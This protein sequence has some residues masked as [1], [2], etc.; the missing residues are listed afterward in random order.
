MSQPTSEC[1][2]SFVGRSNTIDFTNWLA[3]L[4]SEMGAA[5]YSQH[6]L[7][8]GE[9][10]VCIAAKLPVDFTLTDWEQGRVFNEEFELRWHLHDD[11]VALLLLT[12]QENKNVACAD[13]CDWQES[14]VCYTATPMQQMLVGTF[15]RRDGDGFFAEAAVPRAFRYPFGKN[16][17][18]QMRSHAILHGK[19]YR[20]NSR[21]VLTRFTHF[22]TQKQ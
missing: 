1:G 21:T 5:F 8:R 12:E 14:D 6:P 3:Q 17:I 4:F 18:P 7:K 13:L 2:R 11:T 16:V 9:Q 10:G 15:Y 19:H 20:R 22:R